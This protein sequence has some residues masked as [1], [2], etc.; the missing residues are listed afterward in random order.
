MEDRFETFTVQIAKINRNI[1]RIKTEEMSEYNLNGTH[2]SCLY[3]LF[4]QNDTLTAKELCDVCDEDKASISRSLEYLEKSNL[5]ICN[6]KTEKRYNSP[7]SLTSE[8]KVIG[9][10]IANKIENIVSLAGNG[11]TPENR[12]IFYESLF[13][14]SNNLQNYVDEKGSNK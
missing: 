2:V 4:K 5:I 11:L 9:Q 1:K 13:I 14:S 7:L 12:K 6:S 10:S 3:Y 8:G